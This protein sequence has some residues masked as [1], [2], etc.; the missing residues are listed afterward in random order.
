[1]PHLDA[2]N[3]LISGLRDGEGGWMVEAGKLM[4][5]M[6]E[7]GFL[8]RRFMFNRVLNG[9]LMTGNQAFAKEILSLQSVPGRLPRKIRL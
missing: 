5:E 4:L 3:V 9:L 8:P 6:V 7:R 2:Y 1:M